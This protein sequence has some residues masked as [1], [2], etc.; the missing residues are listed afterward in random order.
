MIIQHSLLEEVKYP[1][2]LGI[3]NEFLIKLAT[4]DL[5]PTELLDELMYAFPEE[6]EAFSMSFS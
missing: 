2:Q 6:E 3:F 1:A 4:L 5:I